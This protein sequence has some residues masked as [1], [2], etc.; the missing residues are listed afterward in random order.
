MDREKFRAE[1]K[2]TLNEFNE[3]ISILEAKAKKAQANLRADFDEKIDELK[4]KRDKVKERYDKLSGATDEKWVEVKAAFS[5]AS[6]DFREGFSK[7]GSI[8]K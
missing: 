3:K 4:V 1:A 7:L 8:F 2:K 6:D 5:A